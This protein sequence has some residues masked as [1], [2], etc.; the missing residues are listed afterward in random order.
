M[1]ITCGRLHAI[2]AIQLE[3]ARRVKAVLSDRG[4]L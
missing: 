4:T 2:F 1:Q 3:L